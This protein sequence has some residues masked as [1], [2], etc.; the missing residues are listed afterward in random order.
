MSRCDAIKRPTER[1]IAEKLVP[2]TSCPWK[3]VAQT[4]RSSKSAVVTSEHP[5]TEPV[6]Q[7]LVLQRLC[8]SFETTRKAAEFERHELFATRWTAIDNV[9]AYLSASKF[10]FD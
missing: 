6:P 5:G 4:S 1:P 9:E 10:R 8:G 2:Q 3:L 7:S